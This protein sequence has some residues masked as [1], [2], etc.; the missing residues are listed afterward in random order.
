VP[1][2]PVAAA[3]A[4]IAAREAPVVGILEEPMKHNI[5]I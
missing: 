3:E 5:S 4:E 2:A 1:G